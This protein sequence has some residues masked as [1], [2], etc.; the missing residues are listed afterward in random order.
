MTWLR[1]WTLVLLLPWL[2]LML[3]FW[4]HHRHAGRWSRLLEPGML[5]ALGYEA[6]RDRGR[7]TVW[8]L[9]LAGVLLILALA[10][11]ARPLGGGTTLNQGSLVVVLDNT[12]S[13]AV[14]DLSPNR[15]ERARRAVLDWASSGLFLRTGV[16]VYSGS[17]H[18]LTPFTRDIETLALQL[19][20]L[21]PFIMPQFGNRPDLAFAAVALKQQQLAGQRLHLLWL[22]DDAT[23]ARLETIAGQLKHTGHTWIMPVGTDAGGPIPLPD[24]QGFLNDGEQMVLPKLDRAGFDQAARQ[25]GARLVPLGSRPAA[26]WL[27]ETRR[28]TSGDVA[29]R[30]W[31]YWLLLPAMLLLLPWYRR[32]LVFMVPLMLLVPPQQAQAAEWSDWLLKNREQRAYEAY[33]EGDAERSLDLTR[34]PDL[35][36]AA[37]FEQGDYQAAIEHWSELDTAD[38]HYN[39]GNAL[40][41]SG[42][43]EAALEAYRQAIEKSDHEWARRNLSL[44]EDFLNRQAQQESAPQQP[45]P[46]DD[47]SGEDGALQAEDGEPG[48]GDSAEPEAGEQGAG[49][50]NPGREDASPGDADEATARAEQLR[51]QAVEQLLNRLQTPSGSVLQRKLRFEFQQNPTDQDESELW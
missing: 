25:M 9:G 4:R 16:V 51:D 29:V 36:G 44:V 45:P 7:L 41:R 5:A 6:G 18:W 28:D 47:G 43:L 2:G 46:P 23:S 40:V 34:R 26:D 22:T 31:G 1:P 12:L 27:G 24:G 30:E 3:W 13:M 33:R 39:R 19:N 8:A 20:Q 10:G 14:E 37:A 48:P 11:P 42:E 38:A 32:G 15:A 35:A 50:A 49:E 21:T 17:A